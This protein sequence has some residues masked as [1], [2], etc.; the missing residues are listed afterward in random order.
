MN[1]SQNNRLAMFES[2]NSFLAQNQSVWYSIPIVRTFKTELA[3]NIDSIKVYAGKQEASQV[4]ISKSLSDQKMLI[5]EK[6][7]IIDDSVEVYAEDTGNAE[8]LVQTTNSK[9]DYYKLPNEEFEIK[10]TNV[11]EVV[12]NVLPSLANY[13]ITTVELGI[14][15]EEFNDFQ[16]KRGK[17][18]SYRI[19]SRVA[20]QELK[21]LF[22]A[23]LS[24]LSKLDKILKRYKLTN[25]AFHNGYLAAR[26]TI[27]N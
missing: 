4:F 20:T 1:Q 7:A 3:G 2:T 21:E 18:R 15:K 12:E 25:P 14:V 16:E 5:A 23:S 24:L 6:M 13:G 8:L 19:S 17:P 11:I 9:S 22:D 26:K 10:V 27:N